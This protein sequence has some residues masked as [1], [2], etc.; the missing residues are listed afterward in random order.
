LNDGAVPLAIPHLVWMDQ[1]IA[2]AAAGVVSTEL[3]KDPTAIRD[4]FC[5]RTKLLERVMCV[6]VAST[7][8]IDRL[9]ASLLKRPTNVPKNR[10]L[11]RLVSMAKPIWKS[12]T[13]RPPSTNKSLKDGEDTPDF[14]RFVQGIAEIGGGPIPSFKQVATASKRHRPPG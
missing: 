11:R 12:L 6:A 13:G 2:Q 8:S 9:D 5:E 1:Y 10:A 14:V 4:F 3:V 7:V